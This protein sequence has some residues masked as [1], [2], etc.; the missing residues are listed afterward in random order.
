MHLFVVNLGC[1]LCQKG[2]RLAHYYY[3]YYL[4]KN[5]KSTSNSTEHILFVSDLKLLGNDRMI[6][7]R[8]FILI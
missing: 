7:N 6:F 1:K 5:K 4:K 8:F 2:M 3:Y